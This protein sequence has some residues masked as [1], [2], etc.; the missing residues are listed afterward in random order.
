MGYWGRIFYS[1]FF[2]P[3]FPLPTESLINKSGGSVYV[4]SKEYH[5]DYRPSQEFMRYPTN[6]DEFE[7]TYNKINSMGIRGDEISIKKKLRAFI[8]GEILL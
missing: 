1:H 7:P 6:L 3:I 8:T 2:L 5:H 4:M